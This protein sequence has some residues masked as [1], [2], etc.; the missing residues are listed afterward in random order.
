MATN[1]QHGSSPHALEHWEGQQTL[2]SVVEFIS[3]HY[4]KYWGEKCTKH[5]ERL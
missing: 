3:F 1:S 2:R 4:N 5:H